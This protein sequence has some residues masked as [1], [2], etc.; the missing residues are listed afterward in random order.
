MAYLYLSLLPTI[1]ASKTYIQ[2]PVE[3]EIQALLVVQAYGIDKLDD[4]YLNEYHPDL[5]RVKDSNPYQEHISF[6]EF[7]KR[8]TVD[9]SIVPEKDKVL[10]SD[11]RTSTLVLR[12]HY[13][14]PVKDDSPPKFSVSVL[15]SPMIVYTLWYTDEC[16]KDNEYEF[17]ASTDEE[18]MTIAKT[19]CKGCEG[20]WSGISIT[21]SNGKEIEFDPF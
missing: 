9:V 6:S 4:A 1:Q 20:L 8:L 5:A 12:E 10:L 15:L 21:N 19:K 18:A 17:E 2:L 11:L 13:T 3:S 7:K 14:G 16:H